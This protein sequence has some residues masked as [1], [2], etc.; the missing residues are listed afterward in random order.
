MEAK[1]KNLTK[2]KIN[3]LIIS[4]ILCAN[5]I[6]LIFPVSNII[7]IIMLMASVIF[8][9]NNKFRIQIS[10]QKIFLIMFILLFFF[11]SFLKKENNQNTVLF[12]L[13]FIIFGIIPLIV[14]KK[15]INIKKIYIYVTYICIITVPYII[16]QK[17][18]INSTIDKGSLMGLSYALLPGI[19]SS[20]YILL[21]KD[22]TKIEKILSLIIFLIYGFVYVNIASRGAILAVVVYFFGLSFVK[23][24]ARNLKSIFYI[25][26]IFIMIIVCLLNYTKILNWAQ[27]ILESMNIH[28]YALDK[29]ERLMEDD[30][31]NILNGRDTIYKIAMKDIQE[32]LIMGNG[33]ATFYDIHGGH[34]HNLFIQILYEMGIIPFIASIVF[35]LRILYEILNN[36]E[37]EVREF[38]V[39]LVS[40]SLVQLMFLSSFWIVQNFWLLLGYILELVKKGEEK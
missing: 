1:E 16:Q 37:K 23:I 2:E 11:L 21:K 26:I 4:I 22:F 24:F 6:S 28:V 13:Y 40:V 18:F 17:F 34:P 31:V 3:S 7:V 8:L 25:F 30:D 38:I 10:M 27:N 5:C 35:I 33:I 15:D 29:F 12:L 9:V 20:S 14:I 36:K 39:L 32:H 19:L